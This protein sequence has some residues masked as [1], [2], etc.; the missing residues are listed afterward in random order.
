VIMLLERM[1]GAGFNLGQVLLDNGVL[2][3]PGSPLKLRNC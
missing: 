2:N 3:E 1:G